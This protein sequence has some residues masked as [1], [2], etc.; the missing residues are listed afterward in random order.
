MVRPAEPASPSSVRSPFPQAKPVSGSA[1]HL[2]ACV[3]SFCGPKSRWEGSDGNTDLENRAAR[4]AWEGESPVCEEMEVRK[5][6]QGRVK[7]F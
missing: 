6:Q 2:C 3:H 7:E 4:R 1:P 5:R